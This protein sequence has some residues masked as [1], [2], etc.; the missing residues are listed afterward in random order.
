[1]PNKNA[2]SLFDFLLV[3]TNLKGLGKKVSEFIV[4]EIKISAK[5][6]LHDYFFV[7]QG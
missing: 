5:S 6:V 1:M 4:F 2:L 7:T 3:A